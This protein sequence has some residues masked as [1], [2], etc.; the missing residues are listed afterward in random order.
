MLRRCVLLVLS[1]FTVLAAR[2]VEACG[3]L[4]CDR[5]NTPQPTD[6]PVA[7]TGENVLFVMDPAPGSNSHPEAHF[8][9]QY[10]GPADKFSWVVPVD[11]K[12]TLDIGSNAV[13]AGLE[14]RTKPQI[15]VT[16]LKE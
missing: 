5:P 6:L 2:R 12:P 4:F 14:S 16:R 1:L 7:Q 8:D 13:F 15:L 10:P 11:G 9:I 3:G